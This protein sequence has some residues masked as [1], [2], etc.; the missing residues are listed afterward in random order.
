MKQES[1]V[2]RPL[3]IP[4][5]LILSLLTPIYSWSQSDPFEYKYE[6][7]AKGHITVDGTRR[8]IET[9]AISKELGADGRERFTLLFPFK[10]YPLSLRL[11]L[12]YTDSGWKERDYYGKA[13]VHTS[14]SNGQY[15]E[16]PRYSLKINA[17]GAVLK[18]ITLDSSFELPLGSYGFGKI[19]G[20]SVSAVLSQRGYITSGRYTSERNLEELKREGMDERV[21]TINPSLLRELFNNPE[22]NLPIFV[23]ELTSGTTDPAEKIKLI[24]DWIAHTISY[25]TQAF[26]SGR[27][28]DTSPE[29]VLKTRR[30]VCD[31]YSRLFERMCALAGIETAFIIGVSKGYGYE[32]S[33]TLGAHAWNA[34]HL[35][36]KWYL[37]DTTWDAGYVEGRN[38]IKRYSTAYL[39]GTPE[40]FILDH[41]PDKII[42]QF[43][44]QAVTLEEFEK[45]PVLSGLFRHLG[46]ELLTP[47]VSGIRISSPYS[48]ELR[49]P[50]DV[51]ILASVMAPGRREIRDGISI[52]KD[53]SGVTTVTLPVPP[54]T[55]IHTAYVFARRGDQF[56]GQYDMVMSFKIT[57]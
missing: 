39:F 50:E 17:E 12:D 1:S 53:G 25:D 33:G 18:N 22:K 6:I 35:N 44:S 31:G 46:L 54:G 56:G 28:G 45:F 9:P 29:A 37:F 13:V 11:V 57:R 51:H 2:I 15:F 8:I 47:I 38:F 42:H 26:F 36:G 49:V 16:V 30:S 52:K 34:V 43:I 32:T 48:F 41:F 24:H 7:S 55:G 14:L 10:D 23:S 19:S 27:I 21:K 3:L 4:V 5:F 20:F 40:E